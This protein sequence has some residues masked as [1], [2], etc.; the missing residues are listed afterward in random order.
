MMPESFH[1][2]V[3]KE[4]RISREKQ[5]LGSDLMPQSAVWAFATMQIRFANLN[6]HGYFMTT[7]KSQQPCKS[8]CR[9]LQ[10]AATR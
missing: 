3:M 5:Q 2:A 1:S 9:S 8:K 6:Q 4:P 10:L 7:Q